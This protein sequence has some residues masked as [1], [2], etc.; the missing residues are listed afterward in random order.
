MDPSISPNDEGLDGIDR[1]RAQVAQPVERRVEG[2]GV[3][4]SIPSLGANDLTL[5]EADAQN[6]VTVMELVAELGKIREQ[7]ELQ[8]R[9]VRAIALGM[10]IRA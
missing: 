2:A 4:G 6:V 3:G 7:L 5:A 8:G 10:G 1:R 9:L